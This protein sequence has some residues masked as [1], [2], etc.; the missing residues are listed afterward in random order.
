MTS[1][2]NKFTSEI[3]DAK[4]KEKGLVNKSNTS[5]LVKNSDLNTKIETLATKVELKAEEDKIVKKKS[6]FDDEGMKN[7]LV[8]QPVLRYFKRLGNINNTS[9]LKPKGLSDESIKSP[10]ASNDSLALALYHIN[11][12]YE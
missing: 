1:D 7:Y 3:H 4:I 9:A 6:H 5:N 2:Y 11:T 10:V 12:K 8:F